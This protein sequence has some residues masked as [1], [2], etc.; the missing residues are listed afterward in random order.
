MAI[1]YGTL[2][3]LFGAFPIVYQEERGWSE[4]IGGCAFLGILVGMFFAVAYIIPENIRYNKAAKKSKDGHAAPEARLPAAM[5]GSLFIPIGMFWFAWTN[6]PSIHWIVSIMAGAP[7][8]FGMFLIFYSVFIYL[9]DAYTIYAA[10]AL[11]ANSVLRSIFGAAFPLFTTQMYHNLGI[12]W[13]SSIPA[14]LALA[15]AP[16]PFIFY[17]YGAQ[18]RKKCKYAAEAEAIVQKMKAKPENKQTGNSSGEKETTNQKS[19]SKPIL[20]V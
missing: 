16:F 8:G 10:S 1:V 7:F 12:H 14:F 19:D 3:M 4:G 9:V 13:A 18:I 5:V 11:A 20:L 17:R 6:Y 15:C 2:Y